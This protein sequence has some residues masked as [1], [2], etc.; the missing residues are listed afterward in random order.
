V[1]VSASLLASTRNSSSESRV[2]AV[3]ILIFSMLFLSLTSL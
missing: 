1:S 3:V 2:N